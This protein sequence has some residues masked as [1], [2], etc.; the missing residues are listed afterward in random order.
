MWTGKR[1]SCIVWLVG[2]EESCSVCSSVAPAGWD[3]RESSSCAGR[4]W[5]DDGGKDFLCSC[6]T[7]SK[8]RSPSESE[9]E[10]PST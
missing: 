4:V 7:C 8:C 2:G 6:A 10:A 9:E 3:G 5:L 1:S